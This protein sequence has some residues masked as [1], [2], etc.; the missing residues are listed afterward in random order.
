[1]SCRSGSMASPVIRTCQCTLR[2]RRRHM[3][4]IVGAGVRIPRGFDEMSNRV[5]D[6][7]QCFRVDA[8]SDKDSR[9]IAGVDRGFADAT[10]R[11][12]CMRADIV[13][14]QRDDGG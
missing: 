2:Q 7:R 11:E 6:L 5:G 9:C 12:P 13:L 3:A 8:M 1:M 10:K 4:L 14:I